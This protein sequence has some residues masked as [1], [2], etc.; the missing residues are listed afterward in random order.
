[1]RLRL[2]S[3]L[4]PALLGA[5]A[6]GS[7]P[8]DPSEPDALATL[9]GELS[10][11]GGISLEGNVRI[12]VIWRRI[13]E[14]GA[15]SF[16]VAEDV[17]VEPVFPSKFRVV[18]HNAPPEEAMIVANELFSEPDDDPEPNVPKPEPAPAPPAPAGLRPRAIG[19]HEGGSLPPDLRVAVGS[20]VAYVDENGNGQLDLVEEGAPVFLDRVVATNKQLL[21]TYFEGTI[22]EAFPSLDA[23]PAPGYNF[24]T[25]DCDNSIS[26][27]GNDDSGDDSGGGVA[28]LAPQSMTCGATVTPPNAPFTLPVTDDPGLNELMCTNG[29]SQE[30]EGSDSIGPLPDPSVQPASYPAPDAEGLYCD[31]DGSYYSLSTCE[32]FSEGPCKGVVTTCHS[33]A[34][35]R[36]TPAPAGWPC[37]P[38]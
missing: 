26:S 32:T 20:L 10:N 38:G 1:M 18:L 30:G 2:L 36:P 9:E 29:G 35:A 8:D 23:P 13:N 34:Y 28:K 12:A 17:P 37:P 25:N 5:A 4:L 21:L 33:E 3:C 16:S 27:D 11:Q 14:Q 31:P 24:V 15:I 22:P 7:L 19:A 6:C